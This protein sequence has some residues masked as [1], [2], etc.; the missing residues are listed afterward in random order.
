MNK[1][2]EFEL[3]FN[4]KHIYFLITNVKIFQ[5]RPSRAIDIL[6]LSHWPFVNAHLKQREKCINSKIEKKTSITFKFKNKY[7]GCERNMYKCIL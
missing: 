1:L 5:Q 7:N 3:K 4:N 2:C 6:G